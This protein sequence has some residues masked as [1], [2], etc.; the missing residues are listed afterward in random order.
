MYRKY[1]HT[2]WNMVKFHLLVDAFVIFVAIFTFSLGFLIPA[3][4][5]DVFTAVEKRTA[6]H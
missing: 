4:F 2:A 6:G 5:P 3:T 1:K